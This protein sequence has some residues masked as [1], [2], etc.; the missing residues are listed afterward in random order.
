METE[1]Q[2]VPGEKVEFTRFDGGKMVQD[3]GVLEKVLNDFIQVTYKDA[4]EKEHTCRF[5]RCPGPKSGW[6]VGPS[7]SWRLSEP[8]RKKYCHPDVPRSRRA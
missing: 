5:R 8:E 7:R 4:D 1:T 3:G 6:G 2:L